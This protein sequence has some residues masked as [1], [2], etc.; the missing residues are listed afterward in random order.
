MNSPIAQNDLMRSFHFEACIALFL[1]ALGLGLPIAHAETFKFESK[2][3]LQS[4]TAT[5]E[6]E[7]SFPE[8]RGP[9]PVVILLHACGGLDQWGNRPTCWLCVPKTLSE[10]MT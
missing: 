5:I 10:L 3:S 8:G 9:F 6:G 7:L 1:M 4:Y 2:T